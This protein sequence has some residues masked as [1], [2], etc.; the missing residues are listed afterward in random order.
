M[1][2]QKT[3]VILT[4][5]GT[6]ADNTQV[7]VKK[8]LKQFL[9]DT[10]VVEIPAIIWWFILN[11]VILPFR[12]K[13]ALKAYNEIW[14]D[15]GSPLLS[16]SRKQQQGLQKKL[17]EDVKVELMMRYGEPSFSNVIQSLLAQDYRKLIVLPLYP[18]NSATTTATTFDHIAEVLKQSRAV[19]DVNFIS[20]YHGD[21]GYINALAASLQEHWKAQQRQRFLLMSFHGLPQRNI[22]KGDPYYDQCMGTANLLAT[23]LG[24]SSDQWSISFQSRFGKQEWIKPYTSQTLEAMA[25]KG[26][27]EVDVVCPGFSVDCLET[28]EEIQLQNRDIFLEHGGE[29]YH[30]IPCLNDREDHI[31]MM[32]QLVK[33]YLS[34]S[35]D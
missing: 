15:E 23:I 3:A 7:A 30:Y 24:L 29:E 27:K 5:L 26:L 25:D 8:F 33:P 2:H 34:V 22:D 9:S 16:I 19:P 35:L 28:L 13:T 14:T 21:P 4:N 11:L 12:S 32:A 1:T 18:Q 31:D 10:R 17:G 20:D 6:P